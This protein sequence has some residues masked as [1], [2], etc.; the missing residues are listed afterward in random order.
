M[1]VWGPSV[2]EA[3]YAMRL[4]DD[5]QDFLD[6]YLENRVTADLVRSLVISLYD[7]EV[8]IAGD[9]F[10]ARAEE[11]IGLN[12]AEAKYDEKSQLIFLTKT[13]ATKEDEF[14]SLD[15]LVGLTYKILKAVEASNGKGSDVQRGAIFLALKTN[16]KPGSQGEI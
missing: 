1:K 12:W 14:T 15:S 7:L 5:T 8:S 9:S 4:A 2:T 11:L 6:A 13:E 10:K 16:L 3:G